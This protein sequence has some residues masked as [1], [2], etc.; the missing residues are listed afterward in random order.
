MQKMKKK[1]REHSG[2]RDERSK[3]KES[4]YL[5]KFY[6]EPGIAVRLSPLSDTIVIILLCK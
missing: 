2:K 6:C 3:R 1:R 5:L 4:P